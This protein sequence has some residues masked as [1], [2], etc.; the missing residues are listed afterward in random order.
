ML[1]RMSFQVIFKLDKYGNG[2]EIRLE[3]LG[4][5]TNPSFLNFTQDMF[6]HVCILAGCDY[7]DSLQG[8]G[9][10]K[11]H[12]LLKRF[13][14]M[15]RVL[16]RLSV[17][18]TCQVF[19]YLRKNSNFFLPDDYET[20]FRKADLTFQHQRVFDHVNNVVVPL[21]PLPEDFEFDTTD[22]LGP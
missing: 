22:F 20:N 10:K 8:M 14:T 21:Y 19:A 12:A 5:T 4:A 15:D 13:R 3:N 16:L 11:A 17:F 6:R 2:K 18:N 9:I 7:L 1:I